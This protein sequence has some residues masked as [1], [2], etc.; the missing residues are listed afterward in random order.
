MIALP[1]LVFSVTYDYG[2]S[3]ITN[4]STLTIPSNVSWLMLEYN[5]I[6]YIP[7][8]YFVNM[9]SLLAIELDQN[10]IS[11]IDDFAFSALTSL[12]KIDLIG[13]D[14]EIVTEKM[15]GMLYS[16]QDLR[17][18]FNRIYFIEQGSFSDLNSLQTVWLKYNELHALDE[19]VFDPVNPPPGLTDF[20]INNN[21]WRC[22]C[23][24][25]WILQADGDWL[26]LVDKPGTVCSEPAEL[27]GIVWNNLTAE[28]I[29]CCK[30]GASPLAFH[31]PSN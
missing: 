2:T 8:G 27:S 1:S 28:D 4:I 3:G 25:K 9:D 30:W 22:D 31:R 15:F 21:P 19:M 14:L 23:K 7:Y 20:Q 29:I 17:L 6:P 26:M 10:D 5:S 13:N 18:Y 11:R 16:L 12:I 24:L